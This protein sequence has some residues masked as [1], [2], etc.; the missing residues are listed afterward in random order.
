MSS[1]AHFIDGSISRHI[2]RM[3]S[4][5]AA[6][7]L[8]V[9]AVDI[10]TLVYVAML[11]DTTLLAAV[12]IAKT[13]VFINSGLLSGLILAAGASLS[14][15]MGRGAVSGRGR[16]VTNM[17]VLATTLSTAV[18]LLELAIA[19][20][21]AAWFGADSAPWVA[22]RVFIAITV[23]ASVL[24]CTMQLCAQLLRAEGHSRLGLW[25]VLS[26]AATLAVADPLLIF[27]CG[28]GLKGAAIAYALAALVALTVGL[29]AVGRRIGLSR[30][31]RPKLFKLHARQLFSVALPAMLGNLAMPFAV[32]Y[33][34]LTLASFGAPALAAMAV[35]D[36]LLQFCYCLYFALPNALAP[37]L[38]QN[39]AAAR[40][41]RA[42]AAIAFTR[43]L[44]ILYGLAVWAML[45]LAAAP[46][47][48]VFGLPP[49]A[50]PL[51]NAFCH[52][53]AGLWVAFGLDFIALA[54]FIT[55]GR[56]WWVAAFAWLRGTLG[57]L[58]FVYVGSRVNDGSGALLGMWV[59][60]AMVAALSV[61]SAAAM[62]KTF[63]ARRA[64]AVSTVSSI[65]R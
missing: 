38:A 34:L 1:T 43:R 41:T 27:A 64:A 19:W 18:A 22:G 29:N 16:L 4:T 39:L 44:V 58:P 23:P 17:L 37:V 49:E 32:T 55:M 11:H 36:R 28:L 25:V 30:K 20:P 24:H 9:F 31:L 62:A 45:E 63:F 54:M 14:A 10:L 46:L 42:R 59:G 33:L 5:T 51:F 15:R 26:G 3:S 48:S 6:S 21:I 35:I 8:A 50:L 47:A 53:G 12:G 61:A 7:L 13:L 52:F 2:L 57:T 60:N 40:D 65:Q 56:A